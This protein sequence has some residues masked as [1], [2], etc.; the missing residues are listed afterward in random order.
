MTKPIIHLPDL[1]ACLNQVAATVAQDNKRLSREPQVVSC[2]AWIGEGR[3]HRSTYATLV[4]NRYK[5]RLRNIP[6]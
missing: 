1:P 5:R 2:S 3:G 6:W 4:M